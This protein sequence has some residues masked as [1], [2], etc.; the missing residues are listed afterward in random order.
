MGLLGVT[1]KAFGSLELRH[2]G[3]EATNVSIIRRRPEV[4]VKLYTIK[5]SS[6]HSETGFVAALQ[7]G[8]GSQRP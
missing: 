8:R 6:A 3:R 5:R 4:V 1:K 7:Y 2:D